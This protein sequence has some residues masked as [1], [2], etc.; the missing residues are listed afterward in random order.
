MAGKYFYIS[1]YKSLKHGS[2][3]MDVLIIL[4]TGI[5]YIY[6]VVVIIL[7]LTEKT[8]VSPKTFFETPPMLFTFVSL[9]RWIEHIAKMKTSE[10]LSCLLSLQPSEAIL[11]TLK[12]GTTDIDREERIET[13]LLERG[14]SILVSILILLLIRTTP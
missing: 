3:N 10:A 2:A 4:A 8:Q 9:G 14:D 1:A 5:S 6:S 7:A 11:V 13:E 12:E